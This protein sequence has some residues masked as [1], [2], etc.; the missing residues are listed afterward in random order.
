M[1]ETGHV[2]STIQLSELVEFHS[3]VCIMSHL[4]ITSGVNC[5][6]SGTKQSLLDRWI[7][8]GTRALQ[9]L[10]FL[11]HNHISLSQLSLSR[12]ILIGPC[13]VTGLCKQ[14]MVFPTRINNTSQNTARPDCLLSWLVL[15][16]PFVPYPRGTPLSSYPFVSSQLFQ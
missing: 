5:A 6:S 14:R 12:D 16:S 13:I 7:T 4:V 11:A 15:F 1:V 9:L 10:D 3:I 8:W 2:L